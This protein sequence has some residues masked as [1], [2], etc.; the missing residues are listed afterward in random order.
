MGWFASG[1]G[2]RERNI[3]AIM[4]GQAQMNFRNQSRR[5][6]IFDPLD[7]R[8]QEDIRGKILKM[9]ALLD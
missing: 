7:R 2:V 6:L 1:A 5:D 4:H 3:G 9:R 8:E